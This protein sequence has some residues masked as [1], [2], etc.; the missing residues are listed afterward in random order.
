M[1]RFEQYFPAAIAPWVKSIWYLELVSESPVYE[2]MIVPDGHHELILYLG[3]E[4][5]R[6]RLDSGE[7]IE[8]PAAFVSSQSL[9][10]HLLR[11]Y[12]GSRLY[13][14]R[15]YPHT[16]Y[17]LTGIDLHL[18]AAHPLPLDTLLQRHG[19]D[20]C[21]GEDVAHSFARLERRLGELLRGADAQAP[22]FAYVEYS[23][24]RMLAG[25]GAAPIK[26]L[27]GKTGV[28]AKYYDEL[29]KKYVGIP[30]K[31]LCGILQFNSVIEYKTRYPARSLTEC[32]YEAGYYD[33]SHLVKAF[34]QW[35]GVSPGQYFHSGS[36]ISDLFAGL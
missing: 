7:W 22:G 24:K 14:I 13:G 34:Y 12:A 4:R 23:V 30:P 2:E 10:G 11:M 21:I 20:R 27:V 28:T 1:I 9:R 31:C 36:A 6:R 3:S 15:F 17:F 29:F 33:Q 19:L 16:L 18:L 32:A 8:Q 5:S 26:E 35:A 25:H